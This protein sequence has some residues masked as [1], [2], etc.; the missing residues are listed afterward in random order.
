M[1]RFELRKRLHTSEGEAD[2]ATEM[3]VEEGEFIS[4]FGKSGAGKTTILRMLAGLTD[5]DEGFIEAGGRIW[6]DSRK[7]INLPPQKRKAGMVF[8]DY[9]LFPN[10]TVRENLEFAVPKGR[11]PIDINGILD[12]MDL[13][14]LERRSPGT[15]SGGQKQRVALA[16]SLVNR[17]Q[18]LLLDEP[19]SA[20]DSEMRMKLQDEIA[21]IHRKFQ[22]PTI[23]V[24]H[25][26]GEVFRLSQR[27]FYLEGGRIIRS[28]PPDVVFLKEKLSSKFRFTGVLL[29]KKSCDL[30]YVLTILVGNDIV[31][32]TSIA[33]DADRL[34]LGD[35]LL[36]TSKAF[37]PMV[38][39][40]D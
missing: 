39:K 38:F 40:L 4:L 33:Q 24:S 15:L 25:D 31:K 1:I 34:N 20:L 28:G 3:V 36:I 8:Q 14:A 6:F 5:P 29:H 16:R 2:L 30:I 13:R 32:V 9:A 12:V 11:E 37:N 17:P 23:L 35:K 22:V 18:I 7:N 26:M 27:V 10:M 19:F 21:R